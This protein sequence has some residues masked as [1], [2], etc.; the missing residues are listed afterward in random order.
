MQR[1]IQYQNNLLKQN[2]IQEKKC[3]INSIPDTK[4]LAGYNYFTMRCVYLKQ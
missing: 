1:H 4:G 3:I 2:N